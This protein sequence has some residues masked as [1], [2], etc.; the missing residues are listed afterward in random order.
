MIA[1]IQ[2]TRTDILL[3]Y[4]NIVA[5]PFVHLFV[6][7][8]SHILYHSLFLNRKQMFNIL[9][10]RDIKIKLSMCFRFDAFRQR[11]LNT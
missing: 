2:Q 3:G 5:L 8:V 4:G 6:V 10:K 1:A 7:T 9:I 11:S